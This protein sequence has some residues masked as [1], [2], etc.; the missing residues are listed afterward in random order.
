MTDFEAQVLADLSVLKHQMA[1]LYGDG[2]SGRV[3]SIERRVT[4]HEQAMQRAK[5]FALAAGTLF[6]GLQ[7]LFEFLR[8]H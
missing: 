6:T 2:D 4:E 7:M 8:H 1:S 3:A 5:G